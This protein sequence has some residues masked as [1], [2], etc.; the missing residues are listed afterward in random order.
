[1]GAN[2]LKG[3]EGAAE[4]GGARAA[5]NKLR[6]PFSERAAVQELARGSDTEGFCASVAFLN[7]TRDGQGHS[8]R[9]VASKRRYVLGFYVI[10]FTMA[11]KQNEI[12]DKSALFSVGELC[13]CVGT[14]CNRN[15]HREQQ[16]HAWNV[17]AFPKASVF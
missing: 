17:G 5:V 16:V 8:R 10:I 4:S 11:S 9:H 2:A 14:R 1:M 12:W 3:A 13:F 15:G 7:P 6:C